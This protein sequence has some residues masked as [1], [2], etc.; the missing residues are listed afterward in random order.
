LVAEI[1]V[2]VSLYNF[3]GTKVFFVGR[4]DT[5]GSPHIELLTLHAMEK[6]S[7]NC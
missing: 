5:G 4:Y 6:N 3:G 7:L 2:I 1:Q